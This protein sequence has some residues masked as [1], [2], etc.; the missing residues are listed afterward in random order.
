MKLS[1]I[2]VNLNNAAGLDK[3]LENVFLQH[4][5]DFEQIIID[6]GSTD[7]SISVIQKYSKTPQAS[8]STYCKPLTYWISEPD[9]GIYNAMN[10]GIEIAKGEYL[11]FLNSGDYLINETILEEIFKQEHT[12]DIIIARCNVIDNDKAI[13][14][15]NH[16]QQ[17]TL[18]SFYNATIPHQSTFIKKQLFEKYGLYSENYRIHG[19]YEFWIRCIIK[20]QC[21]VDF[22]NII[23]TNYNLDGISSQEKYRSISIKE[24]D[25]ILNLHLPATILR[26]Y[27][28]WNKK[29]A[30]L[31]FY[32]W[33][34]RKRF[35]Y[36]INK[37]IFNA[38]TLVNKK[39]NKHV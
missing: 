27:E 7:E 26:D 16:N 19:D 20:H 35:L 2:T 1:I 34:K 36:W 31:K 17:L 38:A 39:K 12:A 15:T 11:L 37:S 6:G 23:A 8:Y 9:T 22:S 3:T 18:Q 10:K 21:S 24:K 32:Y 33:L 4:F 5:N 28:H 25:S 14:T 13:F 30:E 29:E